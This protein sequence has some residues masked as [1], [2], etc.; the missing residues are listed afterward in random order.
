MAEDR[1]TPASPTT[2]PD[3]QALRDECDRLRCIVDGLTG[4]VARN[5]STDAL[6]ERVLAFVMDTTGAA[7]AA[8]E[9]IDGG[10]LEYF[11]TAGSLEAFAGLR[12]ARE[13][14]LS[15]RCVSESALQYSADADTDPRVDRAAC[16]KV[17]AR[18]LLA[19]PLCHMGET[20]GVLKVVSPDADAFDGVDRSAL[21]LSAG[22]VGHAI[23]R[24][25]VLDENRHLHEE[26][27]LALSRASTVLASSPTA[28]IVHDLDG[29]VRMWNP[30]AEALLGWSAD[31]VIG[32]PVPMAYADAEIFREV[33]ERIIRGGTSA[34]EI[35][36]RTRKDGS[37]VHVRVSG[38]PVR[39]EDG[40]VVGI[41][42]TLEDVSGFRAHAESLKAATE[43][44]RSI[45]ERS[46]D[47]FVSMDETGRVIEWN[48]AAETLFGWSRQEALLR[49]LETLIIPEDARAAH[50]VGL[51]RFLAS[52][53]SQL[54]GRRIEVMGM[55][56]DGSHV[57]VEL[58][59]N[60]TDIDGRPVFDSFLADISE[61]RA[62]IDELRQQVL[63]DMLTRLPGRDYFHGQLRAALERNRETPRH[64]A[65]LLMNLDGFRAINDLY[66]HAAGDGLLQEVAARLQ[67]VV[68]EQDTVARLGGDEFAIV[69]EGLRDAREDAPAVARKVL[70]AL[71]EPVRLRV[72]PLPVEASVGIALHEYA[73]D[74]VESLMHRG[75][76][77]MRAAKR[78]GGQ[79]FE[80]FAREGPDEAGR[81]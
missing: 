47:A 29:I 42:R 77:A 34:T 18:S 75:S 9:C 53:Q 68:R 66:G 62:E 28:T 6:L 64:I 37:I 19:L 55:R 80:V 38:A 32:Q 48:R 81:P 25:R 49:P 44:V 57:P 21:Q 60:A 1:T 67:A 36:R 8:V 14:S 43:R 70:A 30:A 17:G 39:N 26:R 3:A 58:S 45:I 27:T 46:H 31:E 65:V 51:Q 24:Q 71:G 63:L 69:L 61:R 13:T 10:E 78:A 11:A 50:N 12:L 54:I 23:G 79:R 22:L 40:E 41:V 2:S 20:I 72:S 7:G 56:K 73:L 16:T 59:I 74:D 15:G 5:L 52:G 4:I 76:E 35:L 33:T